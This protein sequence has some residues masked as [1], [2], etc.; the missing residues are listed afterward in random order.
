MSPARRC[1][2]R[3]AMS[4]PPGDVRAGRGQLGAEALSALPRLLMSAWSASRSGVTPELASSAWNW[5]TVVSL[6][7][8]VR[9][10]EAWVAS[11]TVV[12]AAADVAAVGIAMARTWLAKAD[13]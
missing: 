1:P 11:A 3:Q 13:M 12:A 2:G 4:G 6:L 10:A 5:A 9:S 8:V 7:T